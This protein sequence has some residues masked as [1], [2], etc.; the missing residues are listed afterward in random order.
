MTCSR[1]KD[2]KYYSD[3]PVILLK[4]VGKKASQNLEE[5]GVKTIGELEEDGTSNST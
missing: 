1:N 2:I 4:G 3:D 5:I